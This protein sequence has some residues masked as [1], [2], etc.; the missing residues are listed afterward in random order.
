M[1]KGPVQD[2]LGQIDRGQIDLEQTDLGQIDLE[3]TDLGPK[4][5]TNEH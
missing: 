1:V 5:T 3:Q 2:D 4:A